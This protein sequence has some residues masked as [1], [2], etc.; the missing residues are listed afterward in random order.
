MSSL[1]LLTMKD[2]DKAARIILR[3][4]ARNKS[5]IVFPLYARMAW[6]L[7]RRNP[8]MM[9]RYMRHRMK[10]FSFIL[11]VPV[12][13]GPSE[14]T[15]SEWTGEKEIASY[16]FDDRAVW[17]LETGVGNN[18]KGWLRRDRFRVEYNALIFESLNI[19]FEMGGL[20]R[21]TRDAEM[22]QMRIGSAG[23]IGV[24][25]LRQTKAAPLVGRHRRFTNMVGIQAYGCGQFRRS[26]VLTLFLGFKADHL[27]EV[28]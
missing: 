26:H 23:V 9:E 24:F 17:I 15:P 13:S 6:N 10:L 14:Q 1:N 3:G 28:S 27:V 8:G 16:Q 25:P 2:V 22:I 4:V 20:D 12:P 5:L 19:C 11:Q 7:N 18:A 21:D